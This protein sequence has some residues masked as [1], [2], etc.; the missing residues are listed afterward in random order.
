M[1]DV[2]LLQE[3]DVLVATTGST[4]SYTAH[5][6][7]LINPYYPSFR[8]TR[9]TACGES[10]GTEGGQLFFGPMYDEC[11]WMSPTEVECTEHRSD[12]LQTVCGSIYHERCLQGFAPCLTEDI[13]WAS[14]YLTDLD[15]EAFS[16]YQLARHSGHFNAD[17]QPSIHRACPAVSVK[18]E[19]LE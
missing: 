13:S 4:F 14:P 8:G 3:A 16:L 1:L 11:V 9:S 2:S 15:L 12:C 7:G 19:A 18:N 10:V 5:A 17:L 6:R